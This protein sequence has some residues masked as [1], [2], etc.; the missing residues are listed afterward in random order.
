MLQQ[1]NIKYRKKVML[2]PE[3]RTMSRWLSY[4][5]SEVD[6]KL[7]GIFVLMI[8]LSKIFETPFWLN[9]M[10][11]RLYERR[12]FENVH[13]Q[14]IAFKLLSIEDRHKFHVEDIEV[15]HGLKRS[16]PGWCIQMLSITARLNLRIV[17]KRWDYAIVYKF[18]G[19]QCAS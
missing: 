3:L 14:S 6:I 7:L 18:G 13:Q 1:C 16:C 12:E 4:A 19:L 9:N 2:V 5:S 10:S 17:V 15:Y 11:E 8:S